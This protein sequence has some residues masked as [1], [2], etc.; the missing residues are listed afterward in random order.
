MIKAIQELKVQLE[1]QKN[2]CKLQQ[3]MLDRV[4][5]AI[6]QKNELNASVPPMH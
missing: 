6:P 5:K 3:E 1:E 2:I 4:L